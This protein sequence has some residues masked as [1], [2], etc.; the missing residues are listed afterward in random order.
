MQNVRHITQNAGHVPK[1][2]AA[3]CKMSAAPCIY[4][5]HLMFV[6][7]QRVGLRVPQGAPPSIIHE[8]TLVLEIILVHQEQKNKNCVKN[9]KFI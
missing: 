3:Q 6:K 5:G 2:M 1:M 4:V 9:E 7:D 8:K